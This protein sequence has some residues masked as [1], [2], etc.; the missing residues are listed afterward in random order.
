MKTYEEYL[1]SIKDI[2]NKISNM[3]LD[4]DKNNEKLD[5]YNKAL[6]ALEEEYHLKDI[7]FA[8]HLDE[9]HK[10]DELE[11]LIS[12]K[13]FI[14]C[15]ALDRLIK[16]MR[17]DFPSEY[18]VWEIISETFDIKR[19]EYDYDFEY[20]FEA[21]KEKFETEK[22][23]SEFINNCYFPEIKDDFYEISCF[24]FF[25]QEFDEEYSIRI[26]KYIIDNIEL[27]KERIENFIN[28]YKNPELIEK[29]KRRKL[30]E[31]LNKEFGN[32]E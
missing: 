24:C 5:A 27:F 12:I 20:F 15:E 2:E 23:L 9:V 8:I 10:K 11:K 16:R 28:E 30:W 21:I 25:G 26:P 1:K 6:K 31:E 29:E 19:I 3:E 18:K 22:N 13:L 7:K 17:V 14:V 4:I 32:K